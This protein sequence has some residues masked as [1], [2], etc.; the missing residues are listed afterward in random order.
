MTRWFDQ[1]NLSH[2]LWKDVI[3]ELQWVIC[4]R[5]RTPW[6]HWGLS[7]IFG[8][9]Q[10]NHVPRNRKWHTTKR[11]RKLNGMTGKVNVCVLSQNKDDR[12]ISSYSLFFCNDK[13]LKFAYKSI[14]WFFFKLHSQ[15]TKIKTECRLKFGSFINMQ[16]MITLSE[17]KNHRW[18]I[19]NRSKKWFLPN[20]TSMSLKII[21]IDKACACWAFQ[22]NVM[23]INLIEPLK[24]VSTCW[25]R[26][27]G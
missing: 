12:R 22:R 6:W 11:G 3:W 2:H 14:G 24:R 25:V 8:F 10:A 4:L 7:L 13:D 21:F 15:D 26:F 20:K 19:R 27:S 5:G 16:L 23:G 1:S 9:P 18:L 17:V